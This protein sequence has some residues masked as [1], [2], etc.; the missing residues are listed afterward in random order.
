MPAPLQM[1]PPAIMCPAPPA[2]EVTVDTLLSP[3]RIRHDKGLKA[4]SAERQ[5]MGGTSRA[6]FPITSGLTRG[7][8][9]ATFKVQMAYTQVSKGYYCLWPQSAR[10]TLAYAP[11]VF[12]ASDYTPGRCRYEDTLHHEMRHVKMDQDIVHEQ[13]PLIRQQAAARV[14]A[15]TLGKPIPPSDVRPTQA[16]FVKSMK[17]MLE[18]YMAKL[19]K[20]RAARQATI[21]TR[22]ESLRASR[23]C[24]R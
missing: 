14:A 11:E 4:L 22:A 9:T 13:A 23:A 24:A 21:D 12:I 6:E 3:P 19:G 15:L 18:N 8:I 1:T 5:G 17:S 7:S 10:I 16:R 20:T 2:A